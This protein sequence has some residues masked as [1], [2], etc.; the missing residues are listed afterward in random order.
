LYGEQFSDVEEQPVIKKT[1]EKKV[2]SPTVESS[3]E[4]MCLFKDDNNS[5][6]FSG[7]T[8]MLTS[9][10]QVTQTAEHGAWGIQFQP[11]LDTQLSM[12]SNFVLSRL[13]AH[14]F[15]VDVSKFRANTYYSGLFKNTGQICFGFGWSTEA[16]TL[17]I[18]TQFQLVECYK[19]LIADLGKPLGSIRSQDSLLI[20]E[21]PLSSTGGPIQLQN[22]E[23][24]TSAVDNDILGG[25]SED[26]VG[27]WS[28][29]TWTDWAPYVARMGYLAVQALQN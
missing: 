3:G 7:T 12:T 22:W 13:I 8:P 16:I 4:S 5:W 17:A 6:C 21:C 19:T 1:H 2:R 18:T 26:G 14:V 9:G 27:C 28:F 29:A 23:L 10:W 20:D 15:S 25:T 11:Y 24:A